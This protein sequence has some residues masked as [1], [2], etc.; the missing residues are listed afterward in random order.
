MRRRSLVT[1]ATLTALGCDRTG[2]EPTR[3]LTS[4]IFASEQAAC[5]INQGVVYCWGENTMFWEFGESPAAFPGSTTPIAVAVPGLASLARGSGPHLCGIDAD[6]IGVCW[7]RGTRGQLGGG[8]IGDVGNGATYVNLPK[9]W[10]QIA[11]GRLTTCGVAAD[12][13]GYCW[14][15]N[16]R[17]EIGDDLFDIGASSPTPREV[18]GGRR[19][20]SIVTGWTH[21]CGIAE[22]NQTLCWG[23]NSMGQLG[24]GAADTVA[25]RTPTPVAGGHVFVQLSAGARHTCGITNEGVA[26]CWG[27]NR[28]GEV[29][30]GSTFPRAAPTRVAGKLR[31]HLIITSSGFAGASSVAVPDAPPGGIGHTCGLTSDGSAWC[32]GWNGNGQLGDGTQ[33]DRRMPARVSGG[34][35][36]ETLA[37]GGSYSCGMRGSTAW[38]W[39]AN[40]SAQLGN[41]TLDLSTTPRSVEQP[42]TP[43]L[44]RR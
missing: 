10:H 2:P 39:G 22:D 1:L 4:G 28:F 17:G 20:K 6:G 43:I 16:Q 8:E 26:Y 23:D 33:T 29:G 5:A 13:V 38:C 41:G 14:G 31:F 27:L 44:S 9:S 24:I 15:H 7:G 36:F 3:A 21:A 35:T 40:E 32:W 37:L 34:L 25:H 19:W 12:G 18:M 30:D 42:F 11:V